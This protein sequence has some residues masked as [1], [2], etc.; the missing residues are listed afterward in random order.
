MDSSQ[1]ISHSTEQLLAEI[2]WHQSSIYDYIPNFYYFAKDVNGCFIRAN[3]AF[4]KLLKLD[5]PSK[6]LGTTDQDYFPPFLCEKYRKDDRKVMEDKIT[7]VNQMELIINDKG[8]MDWFFTTKTPLLNR[9]GKIL[10]VEVISRFIQ[11]AN[12]KIKTEFEFEQTIKYILNH[13]TKKI[14]IHELAHLEKISLRQFERRFKSC[15]GVSPKQYIE[16]VRLDVACQVLTGSNKSIYQVA[17][18]TGFFDSSHFIARFK[19]RFG[20]A[21]NLFRNNFK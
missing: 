18:E 1:N 14:E 10:G 19:K 3:K 20:I 17:S 11:R 21:P 16:R 12:I 8:G 13:F 4:I 6:F 5:Q 2:V 7:L 15:Y 9:E